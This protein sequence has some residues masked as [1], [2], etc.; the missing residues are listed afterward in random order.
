VPA[1]AAA[2][3][4]P[5]APEQE[6]AEK[7]A[8]TEAVVP[9]EPAAPAAPTLAE[10]LGLTAQSPEE[11]VSMI[12]FV[13]AVLPQRIAELLMTQPAGGALP[14]NQ[15]HATI[16]RARQLGVP[17]AARAPK[18]ARTQS[19]PARAYRYPALQDE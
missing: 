4:A 15:I 17:E 5:A 10:E 8:K 9:A 12:V 6:P 7:E 2:P 19:A 3:V 16:M 1:P 13:A 18:P 14:A 11:L